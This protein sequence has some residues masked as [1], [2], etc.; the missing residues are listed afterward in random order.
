MQPTVGQASQLWSAS[1]RPAATFR[2]IGSVLGTCRC[3][4]RPAHGAQ[5]YLD[6]FAYHVRLVGKPTKAREASA[7]AASAISRLRASA[8]CSNSTWIRRR[9]SCASSSRPAAA[10]S[11]RPLNTSAS[12]VAPM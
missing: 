3:R 2:S 1:S 10:L 4:E 8:V 9:L 11:S 12:L 5:Q 6:E 7:Q